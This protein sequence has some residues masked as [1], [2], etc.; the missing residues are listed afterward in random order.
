MIIFWIWACEKCSNKVSQRLSD[1]SKCF[2][3]N[4]QLLICSLMSFI[5]ML[6]VRLRTM[7]LIWFFEIRVFWEFRRFRAFREFRDV[8]RYIKKIYKT[9]LSE[10]SIQKSNDKELMF[11]SPNIECLSDQATK[12]FSSNFV[13]SNISA[14]LVCL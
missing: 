12:C 3:H 13:R 7:F 2:K 1:L 11:D 9:C 10:V 14:T 4:I 5:L 6:R 8:C